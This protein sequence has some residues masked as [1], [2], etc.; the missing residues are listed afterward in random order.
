[1]VRGVPTA[2]PAQARTHAGSLTPLHPE[3]PAAPAP[4]YMM[5]QFR[6]SG[7]RVYRLYDGECVP[8]K[9][10]PRAP[11]KP[12]CMLVLNPTPSNLNPAPYYLN[13]KLYVA[14]RAQARLHAGSQPDTRHPHMTRPSI[15]NTRPHAAKPDC[16]LVWFRDRDSEFRVRNS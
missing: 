11:P 14:C 16:M 2:R 4:D 6:V 5:V 7:F 1:V 8:G 10:Q 15:L 13:P 12:D 3:T 9:Y